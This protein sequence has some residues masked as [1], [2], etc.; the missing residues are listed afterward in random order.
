MCP[1]HSSTSTVSIF[2]LLALLLPMACTWHVTLA[3]S[4]LCALRGEPL[5]ALA[6]LVRPLKFSLHSSSREPKSW[7][8][9]LLAH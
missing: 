3:S 2:P 6:S 7:E 4:L 9:D 1:L 8:A 5:L